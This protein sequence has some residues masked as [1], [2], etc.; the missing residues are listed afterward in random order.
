MSQYVSSLSIRPSRTN[1]TFSFLRLVRDGPARGQRLREVVRQLQKAN[2]KLLRLSCLDGLTGIANRRKVDEVLDCEWRR[3]LRLATPLSLIMLDIDRFKAYNDS[4][5]HT[6][7]DECLRRIASALCS[8][9]N[10][11]GDVV[12]RY[13]GDEF[14]VILPGT[15]IGGA[16]RVAERLRR[17]VESLGITHSD[18]ERV[19]VSGGY[20]GIVTGRTNASPTD[21]ITAADH[22]LYQAK[23]DGRNRIRPQER[24]TN[25]D[26][27]SAA[28]DYVRSPARMCL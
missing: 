25:H 26:L 7:G 22:A 17:R 9:V 5:G 27:L 20:A 1:G 10:R 4:K 11:S 13:G 16:A 14:A 23:R 12:A 24:A 3:A 19:T 15:D 6:A 28:T 8:V 18:G 21:L 2:Q